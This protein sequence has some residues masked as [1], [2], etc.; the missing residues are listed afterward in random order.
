VTPPPRSV[1]TIS[2]TDPHLITEEPSMADPV[3][4]TCGRPLASTHEHRRRGVRPVAV[5]VLVVIGC[6]AFTLASVGVWVRRNVADTDVWR[7]RS[8]AI[9][10]DPAVQEPLAAW[11]TRQLMLLIDPET[12]FEEALPER[13]RLL[14]RPLAGAVEDF[15]RERVERFVASDRFQ[16]LWVEANALAH[17]T[18]VKVLRGESDVVGA[19]GDRVVINLVPIINEALAD[20]GEASPELFGRTF[21]IPEVQVGDVPDA[22]ITRIERTFDVQLD[23]NFGQF[24]VYDRGQLQALQDGVE[25]AR[26][27]L[28]VLILVTVVALPLALWWS[29]RRRR[30]LLQIL[31]GLAIGLALIRRLAIRGQEEGLEAIRVEGVRGAAAVA[32]GQFVDPLLAITRT[33]LVGLALV[34]AV[35]LLSGPYPWAVRIRRTVADLGRAAGRGGAAVGERAA[36]AEWVRAH[37]S[38]LQ[39][40]GV[41]VA[42]LAL[43]VLDLSF[44]G[45]AV[46][47]ALLGAYEAVLHGV[48]GDVRTT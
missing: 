31:A 3:C 36:G 23:G 30:T 45:L 42:V 18:V 20:L 27:L 14:A 4:E 13:G 2:T 38:A 39:V 28:V 10:D 32:S 25:Q 5:A 44:L 11:M 29:T 26:R 37:R 6:L 48:P 22:V 34:A 43:I 40:G 16:T 21:D 46:L 41:V 24:T 47:V 12:L 33:M 15:V 35:A 1:A 19:R 8:A 9:I 7:E 17:Q